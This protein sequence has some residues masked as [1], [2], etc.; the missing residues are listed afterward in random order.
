MKL[1]DLTD[2]EVLALSDEDIQFLIKRGM[3]EAGIPILP[4]PVEPTYFD[5]PV[6]DLQVH[7]VGS[8]M[9][10]D[11]A[12]AERLQ[13]VV[14]AEAEHLVKLGYSSDYNL[15]FVQ[16]ERKTPDVT[17]SIVYSQSAYA[18][19]KEALDSNSVMR[20]AY[21]ADLRAYEAAEREAAEVRSEVMDRVKAVEDAE[22]RRAMLFDRFAEYVVIADGSR[23]IALE[24]LR[25]AFPM[26]DDEANAISKDA[27]S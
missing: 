3:A 5:V 18:A 2:D 22:E 24:F 6:P 4:R 1:N 17:T 26:T 25:R 11:R 7:D 23:D 9:F 21:E 13:A 14:A 10:A 27:P 15:R 19:H 20:A 8:F 16:S 12:A